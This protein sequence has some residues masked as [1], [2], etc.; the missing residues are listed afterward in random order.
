LANSVSAFI[1]AITKE[2][3]NAGNPNVDTMLRF[4]LKHAL[5]RVSSRRTQ[6]TEGTFSFTSSVDVS[7][8]GSATAGF[9]KDALELEVV[10][11]QTSPGST[12]YEAVRP[13][14][15]EEIRSLQRSAQG[16]S[17]SYPDRYA[18]WSQQLIFSESFS[19]EVIVR[20]DYRR[21]ARRDAATGNLID[22]TTASNGYL[23]L[24]LQL[25]E[26]PLWAKTLEI[27]HA[28]FARD[29]ETAVYYERQYEKAMK[30]LH[31]EWTVKAGAG[32]QIEGY[33]GGVTEPW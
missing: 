27:Y 21:D 13:A 11:V 24:W 1:A 17:S 2:V 29:P 32:M 7:T 30:G 25:G 15:L 23:N 14:S 12:R 20:G 31:D 28:R 18:W 10:E 19:A 16:S 9:P 6:W 8:Y 5:S 4:A 26:D 22:E 33:L 3:A